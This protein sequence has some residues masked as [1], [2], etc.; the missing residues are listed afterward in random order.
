MKWVLEI[1]DVP[2]DA[3]YPVVGYQCFDNGIRRGPFYY[4]LEDVL[5]ALMETPDINTKEEEKLNF[6]PLLPK[7]TLKY[8]VN[9]NQT[10]FGVTMEIDKKMFDIR[11]SGDDEIYCIGFPRM[12]VQY[13]LR[14]IGYQKYCITEMKIYAVEDNKQSITNDTELY[15]FPYP[16]VNPSSGIVCWGANER[17]ELNSLVELERAFVWFVSAPFGEDYGVR[18]TLGINNFRG[19]ITKIKDKPFNDDWLIPVGKRFGDIFQ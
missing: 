18:T 15:Y 10:A 1:T 8:G 14:S 9:K 19:L 3:R 6:T 11:Y 12:V 2:L 5:S 13:I 7:G 17:I 4:R 16:N